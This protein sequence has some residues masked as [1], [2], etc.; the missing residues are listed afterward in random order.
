MKK[1]FHAR[2]LWVF[3]AYMVI[4][5]S[6]RESQAAISPDSSRQNSQSALVAPVSKQVFAD[7]QI[8]PI[9]E[10]KI[11]LG[12]AFLRSALIPGWGQKAVGAPTAARNF[13]VAEAALW[14]GVIAFNVHGNWLEADYRTFATD[15]AAA[16]VQGKDAQYYVD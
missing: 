3:A 1:T 16:E 7:S 14:A 13:F 2:L 9:S 11:S 10:K 12:G 6:V 15:H 5:C 4:V 8:A